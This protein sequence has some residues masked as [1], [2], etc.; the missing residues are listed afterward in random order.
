MVRSRSSFSPAPSARAATS[1]SDP[2]HERANSYSQTDEAKTQGLAGCASRMGFDSKRK[3]CL[4]KPVP[5]L[6]AD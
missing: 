6:A 2:Q 3:L 4:L 5:G 1:A